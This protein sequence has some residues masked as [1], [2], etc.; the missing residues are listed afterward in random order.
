M[1]DQ[2]LTQTLNVHALRD[3]AKRPAQVQ[4]W[5]LAH[6]RASW[7]TPLGDVPVTVRYRAM[8]GAPLL[9]H[10]A[11][12]AQLQVL[13]NISGQTQTLDALRVGAGFLPMGT[14]HS[15][16]VGTPQP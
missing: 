6:V 10:S 5:L 1:A 16:S 4:A 13:H 3:P 2:T 11:T 7:A 15:I 9:A 12:L 14:V 8:R